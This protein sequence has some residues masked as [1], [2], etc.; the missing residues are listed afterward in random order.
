MMSWSET[1]LVVVALW[2]VVGGGGFMEMGKT[3][4]VI[5]NANLNAQ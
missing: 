2:V 5:V 1:E 4:L 3:D